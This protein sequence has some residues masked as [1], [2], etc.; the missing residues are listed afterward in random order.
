MRRD[1]V[2]DAVPTAYETDYGNNALCLSKAANIVRG[3]MLKHS[4]LFDGAFQSKC[5][6]DSVPPSLLAPVVMIL[7]PTS[8][9]ASH[10]PSQAALTIGQLLQFNVAV[11]ATN[12][13]V[14]R[15][16]NKRTTNAC[17]HWSVHACAY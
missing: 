4:Y 2:G 13:Q 16:K 14:V 17:V 8:L 12:S 10:S 7:N 6:E 5:Q 9:E 1:N 15:H 3:D 11:K